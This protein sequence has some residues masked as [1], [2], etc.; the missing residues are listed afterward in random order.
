M[1]TNLI[2][3]EADNIVCYD[4]KMSLKQKKLDCSV[5]DYD[6]KRNFFP[7][8]C[9]GFHPVHPD[10]VEE[11]AERQPDVEPVWDVTQLDQTNL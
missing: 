6:N 1:L 8:L 7:W 2:N 3:K 5:K 10:R 11:G 9:Q 4:L